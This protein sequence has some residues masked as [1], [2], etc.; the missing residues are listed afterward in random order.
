MTSI[1]KHFLKRTNNM[2]P[3]LEKKVQRAVKLIQ[4]AGKVAEE[5]GQ[6]L[7]ICYSGGKDSDVILEL[8]RISGA[9]IRPIYKNTT[10]DPP[11]TIKH[12][13]E[14]SVEMIR[15]QQT[16]R[17]TIIKN[18][19]P[20][21]WRRLCCGI[22]K[23][24][25]ILDYAVVGV[26]REES[27]A[28]AERYHEPETCRVY[29]KTKGVEARLYFPILEWTS[30]DVAQFIK[31]RKI[32]CHPLYYDEQGNFHVE[33]RLGCLC[34]PL[35]GRKKRIADFKEHPKMVRFY[36]NAA[37]EFLNTHPKSKIYKLFNGNVYDWFTS[38][39]FC[40]GERQFKEKFMATPLFGNDAIDTKRFLEQ[41]FNIEL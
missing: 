26:R 13:K 11:L 12:V 27:R 40:D 2:T 5:H 8:A 18:G 3:E 17:E 15:P 35:Q 22:L 9:N 7:E 4:S 25:K 16:F 1:G 14:K 34:C 30:D 38:Q 23:E 39:V 21:R 29:N 33:R 24:Y 32:Q 10:I 36:I 6:P 37:Q 20:N 31:E 28:R 19:M 41:K